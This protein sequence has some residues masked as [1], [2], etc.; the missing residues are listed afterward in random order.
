MIHLCQHF[1]IIDLSTGH[2]IRFNKARPYPRCPCTKP[3]SSFGDQ[4]RP[5][6]TCVK[7]KRVI[8]PLTPHASLLPC[9]INTSAQ[10]KEILSELEN[11]AET[12][13]RSL[14]ASHEENASLKA[15]IASLREQNC[16]LRGMLSVAGM[17]NDLPPI[18]PTHSSTAAAV[19]TPRTDDIP[20]YR[21][22]RSSSQ[23]GAR[24][25]G[26]VAG[27]GAVAGAIGTALAVISCVAMSATG[28]G[29]SGKASN[30]GIPP[31][32]CVG[33]GA[34]GAMRRGAGRRMLLSIDSDDNALADAVVA[35]TSA[36]NGEP[37]SLT[38]LIQSLT[39]QSTGTTLMFA[40]GFLMLV[41]VARAAYVASMKRAQKFG[42]RGGNGRARVDPNGAFVD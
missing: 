21:M 26:S 11:R 42:T 9:S 37:S 20:G 30:S 35:V 29:D 17:A 31:G 32:R 41:L 6:T 12:L 39:P 16:F 10:R 7:K 40:L 36:A 3:G 33:D 8:P 2:H 13:S 25:S 1:C 23:P 27:A 22:Q 19:A 14:G 4:Q 34:G 38:K 18:L 28:Y 24:P 5:A 15:D